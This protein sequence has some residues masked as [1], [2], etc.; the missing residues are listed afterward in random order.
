VRRALSF[1][2]LED[3]EPAADTEADA[4][5]SDTSAQTTQAEILRIA[6][7]M[8]AAARALHTAHEAG[9]IHRDIK[10]G[11]IMITPVRACLSGRPSGLSVQGHVDLGAR[12]LASVPIMDPAGRQDDNGIFGRRRRV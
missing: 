1:I 3:E 4:P 12:R 11:N 5:T 10:P 2:D 7:L 6:K 8:D 9:V